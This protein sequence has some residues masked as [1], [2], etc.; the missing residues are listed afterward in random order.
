MFAQLDPLRPDDFDSFL[1]LLQALEEGIN[2]DEIILSA[3]V[4]RERREPLVEPRGHRGIHEAL[5]VRKSA[6]AAPPEDTSGRDR[7]RGEPEHFVFASLEP[8]R[9]WIS[10]CADA[11]VRDS[12]YQFW[13]VHSNRNA[14][15]V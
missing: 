5:A 9:M 7:G 13:S 1:L 6:L 11:G 2:E 15:M 8:V 3:V 12:V 10:K 4:D 14:N